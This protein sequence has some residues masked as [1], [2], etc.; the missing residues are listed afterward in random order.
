MIKKIWKDPVMSKVI[1]AIIFAIISL[2]YA[3]IKSTI[4]NISF[5]EALNQLLDLKISI[6]Y[7]IG[8]IIAYLILYQLFKKRG[9]YSR[10]QERFRRFN[11]SQDP[12]LGLQFRWTVYFN[13]DIPFIGDLSVFC[14]KHGNTPIR[15][16]DFRCPIS[17]CTN[18]SKQIDKFTLK[19]L[20]E[21]DLI[22]KWDKLK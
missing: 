22:A 4:L 15:F 19:N 7:V 16:I 20:I 9:L 1:A 18:S 6:V 10:K 17:N 21:S 12:E 8:I 5:K 11:N 14:T 2:L 3:K 13:G